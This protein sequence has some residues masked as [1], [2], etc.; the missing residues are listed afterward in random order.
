VTA[1]PPNKKELE[2]QQFDHAQTLIDCWPDGIV[3]DQ[4]ERPDIVV[5][6]GNRI[7]GVEVTQL[8]DEKLRAEEDNRRQV[9]TE[10]QKQYASLVGRWTLTVNVLFNL[11][12]QP[13][14]ATKQAVAGELCSLIYGHLPVLPADK[15]HVRLSNPKDFRS[16]WITTLFL[17]FH[18]ALP[19]GMW[20][21]AQA[22]WVPALTPSKIQERI[23]VKE[24]KLSVYR[25]RAPENWLLIVAGGIYGSSTVS[26]PDDT[27]SHTYASSFDGVVLMD[28]L[29]NKAWSLKIKRDQ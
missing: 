26:I 5:I 20:R 28:Q 10:A 7:C 1:L 8:V 9:C 22:S 25:Q 23:V 13:Y 6:N 11:N 4:G 2:R 18:P 21:P 3:N 15:Y 29:M 27:I 17:S 12:R 19:V 14:K 24:E 16:D